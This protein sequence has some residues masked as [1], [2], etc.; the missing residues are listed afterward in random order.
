M[1]GKI[2]RSIVSKLIHGRR[3]YILDRFVSKV[4]IER[5]AFDCASQ[6]KAAHCHVNN[7]VK[8]CPKRQLLSQK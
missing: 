8:G 1:E 6:E 3:G 7:G 2:T 5:V 4:A